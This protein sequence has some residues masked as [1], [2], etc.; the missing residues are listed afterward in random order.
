MLTKRKN[1]RH[2][3]VFLIIIIIT[4]LAS[5]IWVYGRSRQGRDKLNENID[6]EIKTTDSNSANVAVIDRRADLINPQNHEIMGVIVT[7]QSDSLYTTLVKAAL[8]DLPQEN[9]YYAAWLIKKEPFID[10]Y[11]LGEMY[12]NED[13]YRLTQISQLDR[14]DYNEVAITIENTKLGYSLAP[15]NIVLN[16]K[17]N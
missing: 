2:K 1:I 7:S 3:F 9:M 17:F 5:G 6:L 11:Q 16:G 10:F 14:S 12:K 15:S 13:V 8:P 4:L